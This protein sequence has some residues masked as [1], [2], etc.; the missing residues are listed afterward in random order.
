MDGCRSTTFLSNSGTDVHG[1]QRMNF[2]DPF[3]CTLCFVL[4]SSMLTHETKLVNMVDIIPAKHQ[5]VSMHLAQN[6]AVS[7]HSLTELLT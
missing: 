7:K 3:C 4:I 2:G 6:I 1:A 5:H